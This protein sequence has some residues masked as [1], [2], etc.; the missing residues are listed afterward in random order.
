MISEQEDAL[1]NETPLKYRSAGGSI[2][3]TWYLS[4][5]YSNPYAYTDFK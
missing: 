2:Y 3:P 4:S 5:Y 1:K